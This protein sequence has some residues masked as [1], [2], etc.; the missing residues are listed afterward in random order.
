MQKQKKSHIYS[1]YTLLRNKRIK[2]ILSV[3]IN[4]VVP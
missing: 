2:K 1:K 4:T 3:Y